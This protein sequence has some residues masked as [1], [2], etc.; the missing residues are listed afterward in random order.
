MRVLFAECDE[1]GIVAHLIGKWIRVV[2]VHG[3]FSLVQQ[4]LEPNWA[5]QTRQIQ[6]KTVVT[7]T[8]AHISLLYGERLDL[9]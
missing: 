2:F 5:Q 9:Q 1:A 4:R 3:G 8:I 7:S 6:C